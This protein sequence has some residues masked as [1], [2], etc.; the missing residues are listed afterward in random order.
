M[1]PD[2][3]AFVEN[4]A[5]DLTVVSLANTSTSETRRVIV[6]A[7]AFA[8]H[9]F[10]TLEYQ[11]YSGGNAADRSVEVNG[12]YVLVELPPS[13]WITLEL[14]TER[15]AH[16]PTYA[17]PWHE[18]LGVHDV[19]KSLARAPA[20]TVSRTGNSGVTITF[21]SKSSILQPE[22]SATVYSACGRKAATL[23]PERIGVDTYRVTWDLSARNGRPA[24]PNG[25]YLFRIETPHGV[26][27]QKA[28]IAR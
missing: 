1:P 10:T 21:S 23:R 19:D 4:I 11:E 6:Q 28:G 13:T 15:F 2:V 16:T 26:W 3:A 9:R 17:F 18:T 12:R 27:Y 24:A 14:G 8:E 7:G 5:A 22:I 20:V 25:I